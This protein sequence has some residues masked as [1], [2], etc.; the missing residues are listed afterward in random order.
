MEKLKFATAFSCMAGE[1]IENVLNFMRREYGVDY[2]DFITEPGINRVLANSHDI[3]PVLLRKFGK[4]MK[5][6]VIEKG[7]EI[8]AIV[9]HE[10]CLGNPHRREIQIQ[11]LKESEKTVRL[12]G[13]EGIKK[14]PLLWVP[15][16]KIIEVV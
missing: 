4:N 8:V 11:H 12:F 10:G 1:I 9:G 7:S 15:S 14:I 6:S 2:V 13:C 16:N 5:T 3:P